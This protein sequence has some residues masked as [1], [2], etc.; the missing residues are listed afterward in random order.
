MCLVCLVW[1]AKPAMVTLGGLNINVAQW[2]Q[3]QTKSDCF[4]ASW[5]FLQL[6]YSILVFKLCTVGHHLK[7]HLSSNGSSPP[8]FTF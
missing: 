5:A 4:C 8:R 6:A 1:T 2:L 7:P 3:Q